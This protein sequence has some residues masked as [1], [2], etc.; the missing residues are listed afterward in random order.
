MNIRK[1]IQEASDANRRYI[2]TDSICAKCGAIINSYYEDECVL[3][4]CGGED[5][6]SGQ[7]AIDIRTLLEIQ[8]IEL[9]II[10]VVNNISLGSRAKMVYGIVNKLHD[11]NV[12]EKKINETLIRK[13]IFRKR[14]TYWFV[15]EIEKLMY[16]N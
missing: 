13:I 3:C 16:R 14:P 7:I 2:E 4:S 9:K 6:I 10:C 1:D 15:K 5:F 8:L 12:T 11:V